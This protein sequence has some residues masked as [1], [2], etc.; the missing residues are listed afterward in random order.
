MPASK[1]AP[2]LMMLL[3]DFEAERHDRLHRHGWTMS[4]VHTPD[5][6]LTQV[7]VFIDCDPNAGLEDLEQHGV[8]IHQTH[9][10]IRTALVPLNRL[11]LVARHPA[12]RRVH[13]SRQLKSTM[14]VAPG[15]VH[16]PAFT[17]RTG[18]H[19]RGV[20]IGIIDHGIDT[21]HPAFAGRILRIW[22]Q[23][24]PGS[25]VPE[26]PYGVEL[27]P[28]DLGRSADDENGHGTHV[29]GIAVGNH[30][31][32]GG[33][34]SEAELIV[35]KTTFSN[36]HIVDAM[37][38]IFRV[39]AEM[40][41]PAVAN[42]SLGGQFDPHDG[43]DPLSRMIDSK[44]GPGRIVCCAAGNDGQHDIHAVATVATGEVVECPFS[45]P[46][47]PPPGFMVVLDG[48]YSGQDQIEIAVQ[49][50]NGSATPFQSIT[51]TSRSESYP[52]PEG[53]VRIA[54]PGPDPDNGDHN[55]LIAID[56][57]FLGYWPSASMTAP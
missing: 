20:I 15:K 33:V 49:P 3:E 2:G 28:P 31:A 10:S 30:D 6:R 25:G 53:L 13:P 12:V 17:N 35:V 38:Y 11:E 55:F 44:S 39:A 5:F 26:G 7:H 22:D 36:T 51:G 14:D 21:A 57:V 42:M 52:L 24:L 41:R 46:A 23:T 16:L 19:G 54:T 18:L 56:P 8:R 32:Y 1:I 4:L 27:L 40:G 48:W 37:L 9:G 50:H 45:L 29:A 47:F 34:A 43:T